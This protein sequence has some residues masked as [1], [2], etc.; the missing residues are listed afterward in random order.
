MFSFL[1]WSELF[2]W[3]QDE[4]GSDPALAASFPPDRVLRSGGGAEAESS[5]ADNV[6]PD[7][8]VI[9]G[10]DDEGEAVKFSLLEWSDDGSEGATTDEH[11]D[12][13][14]PG[15]GGAA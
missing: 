9:G 2:S 1:A 4:D 11:P 13:D 5:E 15:D 3:Q 14:G 10:E 8:D 7:D 6:E 12:T